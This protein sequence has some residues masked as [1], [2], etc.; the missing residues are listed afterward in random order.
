V[1]AFRAFLGRTAAGFAIFGDG[2][3]PEPRPWLPAEP[4][5]ILNQSER[6][7][8]LWSRGELLAYGG[9]SAMR[10]LAQAYTDWTS[11]G[12]PGLAGF[13]LQ[14]VRIGNAPVS[15]GPVWTEPR[16][17]TALVW[18]PLP[19]AEDWQALLRDAP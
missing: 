2:E 4:F 1:I 11:Y 7:V 19:R 8:A 13:A 12:L 18:R 16:G 15:D 17:G 6:S 10:A 9:A 3:P 5:G 14:V